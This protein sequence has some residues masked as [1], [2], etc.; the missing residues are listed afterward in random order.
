[1]A[2][3]VACEEIYIGNMENVKVSYMHI[4]DCV[5]WLWMASKNY[6]FPVLWS[7]VIGILHVSI[8]LFFV[9]V[10]KVLIDI[11]TGHSD[12]NLSV[13]IGWMFFCMAMQLLLSVVRSRLSSRTEIRFRNGMRQRLFDHLMKSRW[14]ESENYHTGDMLNRLGEDVIAVSDALCRT[15]PSVLTTLFQLIGALFFLS[16]LDGRLAGILLFIMPLALLFSTGIFA[17][18]D[19]D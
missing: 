3:V 12:G 13:Y 7:G 16:R 6:R 15:V 8:S 10:C 11:A 9:Y 18:S 1:M 2:M 17:T 14:T 19:F 4:K 5:R